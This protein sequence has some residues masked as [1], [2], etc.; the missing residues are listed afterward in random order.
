M[1]TKPRCGF[2][3]RRRYIMSLSK[4]I[5]LSVGDYSM[6]LSGNLNFYVNDTLDLIFILNKWGIDNAKSQGDTLGF[7]L[8]DITA[9]LMIEN[10]NLSDSIE[11]VSIVN[12][13][14]IFRLTKKY[15]I[16]PG[17]GRMQLK[18]VDSDGCELKLPPFKYEI[19]NTI[20][21]WNDLN[22]TNELVLATD[23]RS[24]LLT[25]DGK[26][27]LMSLSSIDNPN[28]VRVN[29]LETKQE[30]LYD[31]YLVCNSEGKTVKIPIASVKPSLKDRQNI[32]KIPT[33]EDKVDEVSKT[34][35][36]T[37]AVRGM[38]KELAESGQIQAYSIG[39]QSIVTS[40]LDDD[41]VDENTFS[42]ITTGKNVFNK[43]KRTIGCYVHESSGELCYNDTYDTTHPIRVSKGDYISISACRKLVFYNIDG[44]FVSGKDVQ[45]ETVTIQSPTNGYIRVS[46]NSTDT[47]V[48][49]LNK[50][51]IEFAYKPSKYEPFH[52]KFTPEVRLSDD[53]FEG[54]YIPQTA[55]GMKTIIPDNVTF[56]DIGNMYDENSDGVVERAHLGSNGSLITSPDS[57]YNVSDYISITNGEY[58]GVGVRN[59][60]IYNHDN[61]VV[62]F[63]D[64][65]T[66]AR[67]IFNITTGVKARI[68]VY[69]GEDILFSSNLEADNTLKRYSLSKNIYVPIDGDQIK[70]FN[71]GNIKDRSV[72]PEKCDFIVVGKNMFDR[73]AVKDGGYIDQDGTWCDYENYA[74]S[75]YIPFRAN[76][77]YT[78]NKCRKL[79][80]YNTD[81]IPKKDYGLNNPN[82]SKVTFNVPFDGYLKISVR[83]DYIDTVQV[84]LGT[85]ITEFESY[86]F[87]IPKMVQSES[88]ESSGGD[89]HTLTFGNVD[90]I[91]AIGDSYTE[92]HYTLKGKAY[93]CKLSQFSDYNW[94]N[95]ARSGDT[96]RGN[97]DRI[98]NGE[99]IYHSKLSW[100]DYKP[101]YALCISYTNDMKYMS[102]EQYL[103]DL[104]AV[105]ETVKSL[106]AIPIIAT[107]YH[108]AYG[109]GLQN[110]LIGVANEYG[111]D[112]INILPKSTALRG[113]DYVPFWGGSHPGTRTNHILSDPL[114]A[115]FNKMPRPFQSLKVFRKRDFI[116]VNS[117]DDL[118][119]NSN[120]ERAKK[121]KEIMIGHSA[122]NK[123]EEYDN[124][125][126]SANSKIISEY[127]KLLNGES[128]EFKDYALIDA[129]LPSTARDLEW[130]DLKISEP[131][132]KVYIKDVLSKPYPTPTFYQRFDFNGSY[133]IK[134]GDTY[135]SDDP[136]F[137]DR[138]FVVK[139]VQ[140][141]TVLM[142]PC[143]RISS[144]DGTLTK[145]SGSGDSSISYFYT[146]V[147][148]SSNYPA[149]KLNIGHWVELSQKNGVCRV[150]KRYLEKCMDYDK[151]SF[152][153]YK[154]GN[155]SLSNISVDFKG[156]I[157]KSR[158][159]LQRTKVNSLPTNSTQLLSEQFMGNSSQLQG[160]KTTGSIA[161][162]MP[163]DGVLPRKCVGCIDIDQSKTIQQNITVNTIDGEDAK[164]VVRIWA[165]YFPKIFDK[166]T[167]VY[168]SD[169]EITEDTFDYADI[170]L[171]MII[172]GRE[173][174]MTD[175][176]GLGWKEVEF[177]TL[178][179]SGVST[180]TVK[181]SSRNKKIQVCKVACYL[182]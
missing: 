112:V 86:G 63:I 92:S 28:I 117:L 143:E 84:E 18:L 154:S 91:G 97:L 30:V 89:I 48:N 88:Q 41:A 90:R 47:S 39:S 101:T 72:S 174:Q 87:K 82:N 164:V 103:N 81:K 137:K 165:R 73:S 96:Y 167:M 93:I 149:G 176:V 162:Y 21:E 66:K 7:D 69:R 136:K 68:S 138:L 113:N 175:L 49:Q 25:E 131:N 42:Y 141:G 172:N 99:A 56:I 77:D 115:Y 15:T 26:L 14:I 130:V 129:I 51:Q 114:E 100:K 126:T 1:A 12:N 120:V 52:L 40:M 152:L 16:L 32:A 119:F 177:E 57:N 44:D 53:M 158:K 65:P 24:A 17:I 62:G 33:L 111:L 78:I 37:E 6:R 134:V 61:K 2:K 45:N 74:A 38:V 133:N 102:M 20:N 3:I 159:T 98:R 166:N 163:I 147:G 83:N 157:T 178:I 110:G 71:G 168:P 95:F 104:R 173:F 34:G 140:N 10:A 108:S 43:Q 122:I 181:V 27:F 132:C 22:P 11:A 169:S 75:E 142:S 118:V 151:I 55:F 124:C 46:F 58:V 127:L 135:R 160:W 85:E 106:G 23:N 105:I 128:V 79:C 36:T 153:L 123:P 60:V 19:Q 54:F 35:T 156:S 109:A 180:A 121:F 64:N 4:E 29:D 50:A 161:P 145:V 116:E 148:F 31:D 146:A 67:T 182:V 8:T 170:T 5:I 125:T 150:H 139:E 179:P 94:E 59:V 171:T 144:E 155:F 13:K 107:E 80:I 76:T 9:Y 70:N